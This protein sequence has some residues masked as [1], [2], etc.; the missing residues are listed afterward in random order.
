MKQHLSN[1]STNGWL[2]YQAF[3][4]LTLVVAALG[5]ILVLSPSPIG[6]PYIGMVP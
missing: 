4:V 3:G 1:A 2:L 6:Q 5:A